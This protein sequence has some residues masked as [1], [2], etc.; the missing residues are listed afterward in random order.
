MN[1]LKNFKSFVFLIFFFTLG[2]VCQLAKTNSLILPHF[3][4]G[5][6]YNMNNIFDHPLK[7]IQHWLV[8]FRYNIEQCS[9]VEHTTEPRARFT[10]TGI[11]LD[12]LAHLL[13]QFVQRVH[14]VTL[15]D[16]AHFL[17]VW[18]VER[19]Q[20]I[21]DRVIVFFQ[22]RCNIVSDEFL[23]FGWPG[24]SAEYSGYRV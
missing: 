18:S 5:L 22:V 20:Q 12:A 7:V 23:K 6:F 17:L 1:T 2:I 13:L 9:G 11:L 4:C 16:L 8:L 21:V 3:T 14:Q 10:D 15:P 19:L 24:C